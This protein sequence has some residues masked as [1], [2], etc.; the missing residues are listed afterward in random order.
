[1]SPQH[2]SILGQ[3]HQGLLCHQILGCLIASRSSMSG[4]SLAYTA[5]AADTQLGSTALARPHRLEDRRPGELRASER[6]GQLR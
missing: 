4:R 2:S 1:M 3:Q 5:R 6:C